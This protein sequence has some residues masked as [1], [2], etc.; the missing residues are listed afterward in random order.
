MVANA[1]VTVCHSGGNMVRRK[2]VDDLKD[3]EGTRVCGHVS[4]SQCSCAVGDEGT[5]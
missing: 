1:A 2:W 3:V 5:P 4:L